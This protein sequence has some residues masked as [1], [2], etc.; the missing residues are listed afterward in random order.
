M[1][2]TMKEKTVNLTLRKGVFFPPWLLLVAMVVVSLTNGEVFL[3]GLNTVTSWILNNFAWAFNL[4]TLACVATVII[5]YFS[6]L[7]KVRIG[8]SKARPIMKYLDLVWITLCTTIAAGILFWACAEP[9]YHLYT[10]AVAEGVEPGSAG[11]AMFAMKTMFL[12]WTW[13]PYAIYTVA[14]LVFAFVFYNMKQPYSMGSALVPVFGEK[15]KKYNGVVD[16]ICLFALVAGMAASLGT[17]TMTIAGGIEKVFGIPSGP[18]SWGI[19]IIVIVTTFIISSISGIMK[20]IRL[21]S[22]INAKVYMLLLVFLFVFGPTAFMLN[23]T[24]E[25]WGAYIRDFFSLSLMTGDIFQDGWSKGW[26]IFY[27]CN[28]LAWTPITAVFL[29]KILK[30]YTIKDAIK[31]NFV[32]PAI[33]STI[34]MGLFATASI[35]YELNGL[36]LY[37]TMLSK[38]TE[39]AVYAV[40]E[41]LPLSAIIIPFYLFIVFISFVTASDSNT[42]A[43]AGLCTNGVTQDDQEAPAWLKV[44]WG[45]SIALMT[46]LLISFAGIDGIKAASNLGGFPNMFLMIIMIV[47]LLKICRNPQKYDLYKEDYDSAGRP[48]ESPRLPV[49]KE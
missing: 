4:T 15:V 32:I 44:V 43:M 28:W 40:F 31:C 42:N 39:S 8:G 34:W 35:Y 14:T 22:S 11:A 9:L 16:V 17:G 1:Q 38:G 18:A 6:P 27:W 36:G 37:D 49:E 10:P 2:E 26:P 46:W 13:S 7:G 23:F 45:V 5:V 25:S 47:G 20:G 48:I 30:G 12:E 3:S 19:I 29:G 24:A 33:F 21:L 41:Q